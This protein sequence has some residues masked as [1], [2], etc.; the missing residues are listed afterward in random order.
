[1]V[2]PPISP[3]SPEGSPVEEVPAKVEPAQSIVVIPTELGQCL[4]AES[5]ESAGCSPGEIASALATVE[6]GGPTHRGA[7]SEAARIPAELT[8][9]LP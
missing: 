9:R 2:G 6:K 8:F 4:L 7:G 1:V 3:G 5:V